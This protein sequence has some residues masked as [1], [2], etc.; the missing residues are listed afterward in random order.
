M[1]KSIYIYSIREKQSDYEPSGKGLIIIFKIFDEQDKELEVILDSIKDAITIVDK[2][3]ITKY[4]NKA[5]EK[6]YGISR[7]DIVEK[8]IRE[9]FPSSLLPRIIKEEKSYENY[10]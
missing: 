10:R 6:M 8:H 2:D 1:T 7:K 3:C 4:W 9:F 5:A